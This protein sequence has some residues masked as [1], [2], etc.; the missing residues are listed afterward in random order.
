MK[1]G[2]KISARTTDRV[3]KHFGDRRQA[4]IDRS[5]GVKGHLTVSKHV[6]LMAADG[7][8]GEGREGVN[9]KRLENIEE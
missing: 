7:P 8:L 1:K 3:R 6:K 2:K 9:G 4:A 5:S